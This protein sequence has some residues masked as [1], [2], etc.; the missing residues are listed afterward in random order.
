MAI[1]PIELHPSIVEVL[2][3]L[4]NREGFVFVNSVRHAYGSTAIRRALGWGTKKAGLPRIVI[5]DLRH[6]ALTILAAH[7]VDALMLQR[8]AGHQSLITTQKYIRAS[9]LDKRAGSI[10]RGVW[11]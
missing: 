9:A 6:T 11:K 5:H 10:L 7:G 2:V 3:K 4:D 1:R 8:M